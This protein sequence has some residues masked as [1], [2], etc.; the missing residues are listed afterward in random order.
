VLPPANRPAQKPLSIV[1][2]PWTTFGNFDTRIFKDD[3]CHE[4]HFTAKVKATTVDG[5]TFNYKETA[6]IEKGNALKIKDELKFWFPINYGPQFLHLRIKDSDTRVHYDNG[7]TDIGGEKFNFYGSFGF[8]RDFHNYNVKLG[9]ATV[10][11]NYNTDNRVSITSQHNVA[12]YHK[13]LLRQNDIRFGFIGVLDLTKQLLL[14]KDFLLGY[15]YREWDFVLKA[16]QAF[17]K[18]T[19]D[20]SN[21]AEWFSNVSL[22]S[23]YNHSASQKYALQLETDPVKQSLNAT[24]LL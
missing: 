4:K 3:F 21:F 11:K 20:F 7:V 17:E 23:T 18:P 16:E 15:H 13:T 1:T 10:F 22:I 24:A 19:K 6:N 9:I 12:W 2:E 5:A 8:A 14:K